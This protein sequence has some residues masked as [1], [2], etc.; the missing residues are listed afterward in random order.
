MNKKDL[1]TSLPDD[2]QKLGTVGTIAYVGALFSFFA[3]FFIDFSKDNKGWAFIIAGV[4]LLVFSG[5]LYLKEILARIANKKEALGV[6][7]E[8]YNR[9]A[10]QTAKGD[11]DQTVAMTMTIAELPKKILE[12]V[13]KL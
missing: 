10:E 12:V 9:L 1:L 11:K 8:V 2:V 6:L 5:V 13:D 4:A 3:T 7:R